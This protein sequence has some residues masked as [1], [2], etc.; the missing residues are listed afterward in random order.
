MNLFYKNLSMWLI[1]GLTLIMLFNLFSQPQPQVSEMSYSDFLTSV[2]AG[3]IND[4]VIQGN[5]ITAKGPDGRSFEVVAP[6]DAEMIP[7]LRRQGVNIKVEEEPKTPWYFTMLISWFPF[8]L[9][10]GVWIFFMRQMQMGGGK[11]MSFGKSK[12]RLLDQQTSKVTFEDV[13]GIDEAKEEL[14][15]IIDFLK[16]PSKFTRL[17]GR[18]PKGVLLMGSPGTGKTLLAKAIAGEA[19]VPFFSISGSDFVEMFVGVGAS[20]VRD[21]FVQ[22]KKN[23][24]CIIFIDEIDAVGRHRGAGLGGGHDEREQTLN[25]LLVE[26]DGFE[27]NEGVII[28]AATNRPDVLDPALLRPGRFD[29]QVMVPPPDVR[30]REQILKV[31]AKK[32]QM[33]TNVDWTRI[34]RG[35]PG[36]SGADLENMVNE[37]ALLAARENAEIITEKH[38]EQ[39]KD[40]VMMG[41]ERRSMI[42]TEAEKK[43]TAYHEAGH[44]LVAKMLPGTDP[45]HKVTIIPRGRALGLTQQLP[46]EE[47]YTY[48]RSYLLNNLCILLGGRTAE[49]LVFNEITTGAGNDIERATAMARKMVCEWGMSDAMGPLTFGKKEEQIFL[50]REISQHRDYSESTAIQIDNEVRRMI[51]EAKDKVRELL[52]ENIATLHQVAEELLEKETLMLEDIERIIREQRGEV[53]NATA[54]P[55]QAEKTPTTG[56]QPAG[57][58]DQSATETAETAKTGAATENGENGADSSTEVENR[59]KPESSE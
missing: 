30:G 23:A 38:L 8:L 41:S 31:H 56:D 34:A 52:E 32:T 19:G 5:K 15:E 42:I 26:M 14:E 59:Q 39:A 58:G 45:L 20:R 43:I 11:A 18:I 9:L 48:P 13:A 37:A 28:V 4:V 36:F 24:P 3:T 49:E 40:K 54:E 53:P 21:L 16:D 17:G 29:R 35:T 6:D 10:I 2:E 33:D 47:K 25:Q 46:L 7:L 1:I 51:M 55:E 57:N 27:A 22:G 44:A 12:A 50:G